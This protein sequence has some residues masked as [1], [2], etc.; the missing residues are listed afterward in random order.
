MPM[1]HIE[2]DN[3]G[4]SDHDAEALA[5]AICGIVSRATG[6]KDVFVYANTAKIKVQV[7]PIEI[8]VRMT[9]AKIKDENALMQ[10]IKVK[11]AEWKLST[12]FQYPINLTL[13]PVNWKIE[14][15]I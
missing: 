12:N 10:D 15:G 3:A 2:Y 9:A 14:I 5:R 6:I 4:V 13:I 8:F 11:L 1:I 7:A